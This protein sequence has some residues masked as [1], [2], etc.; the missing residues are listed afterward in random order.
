MLQCA[1][2]EVAE[3]S[4]LGIG[5]AHGAFL[6]QV[7]EKILSEVL[8]VLAAMPAPADKGVNRIAIKAIKFL[9]G[10]AG[11]RSAFSRGS[12]HGKPLGRVESRP[13]A[14]RRVKWCVH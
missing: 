5:P 2:Q 13:S 1:E 11:F 8:R 6:Q 7:H 10:S 3:S 14:S 12:G 9:Q 4:T